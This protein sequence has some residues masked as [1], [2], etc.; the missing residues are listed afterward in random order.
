MAGFEF[1]FVGE[2]GDCRL[3]GRFV[4]EVSNVGGLPITTEERFCAVVDVVALALLPR[5]GI[6]C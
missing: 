1:E 3:W 5:V 2:G 6:D 4:S